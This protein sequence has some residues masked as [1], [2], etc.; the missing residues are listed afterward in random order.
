MLCLQYGWK[1]PLLPSKCVCN[2]TFTVEH[3]LSC[4]CCGFPTIHPDEVRNITAHVKSNVSH[5]VGIE[6]TLQ[7]IT[8]ERLFHNTANTEDRACVNVTA[9]GFWKNDRQYAFFD[10]RAFNPLAH[11]SLSHLLQITQIRKEMS[12]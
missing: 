1:P 10:V 9:Q 4:L 11:T 5:N 3:T 8:D 2:D 7:P 6:P 12:R